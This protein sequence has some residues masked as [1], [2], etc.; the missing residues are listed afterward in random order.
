MAG[1][2]EYRAQSRSGFNFRLQSLYPLFGHRKDG[3]ERMS[4]DPIA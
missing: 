3:W 4:A 2:L 1:S